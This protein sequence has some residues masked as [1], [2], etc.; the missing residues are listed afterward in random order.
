M[1]ILIS[2]FDIRNI[3]APT[4]VRNANLSLSHIIKG[5]LQCSLAMF[6]QCIIMNC[7]IY[8]T[9]KSSLIYSNNFQLLDMTV[10]E[11]IIK[12]KLKKCSSSLFLFS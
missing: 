11:S 6:I 4:N 7:K 3:F 2:H 1:I 12:Y 5:Y 9:P 8:N 10:I